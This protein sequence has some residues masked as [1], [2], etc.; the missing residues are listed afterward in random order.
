MIAEEGRMT[1]DENGVEKIIAVVRLPL[2]HFHCGVARLCHTGAS[3]AR[4]AVSSKIWTTVHNGGGEVAERKVV[5]VAFA[6]E[7]ERLR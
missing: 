4:G 7:D 6:I 1:P 5:F 3:R 2:V